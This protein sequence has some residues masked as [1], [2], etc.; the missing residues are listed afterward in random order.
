MLWLQASHTLL[1]NFQGATRHVE[2]LQAL[3]LG[4]FSA[5]T[6]PQSRPQSTSRPS[7]VLVARGATDLTL[8][9]LFFQDEKQGQL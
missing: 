5:Y 1:G 8:T 3:V 7:R 4:L 6:R 2:A 9:M